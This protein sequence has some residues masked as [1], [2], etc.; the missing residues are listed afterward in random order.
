MSSALAI[1]HTN[2]NLGPNDPAEIIETYRKLQVEFP[3]ATLKA[4]RLD[5]YA[6]DLLAIKDELPVCTQELG[7]TWIHGAGTDPKKVAQYRQLCRLRNDW[8][9]TGSVQA[10]DSRLERFSR[11]LLLVPEHTW[12]MDEKTFLDDYTHY[13]VSELQALRKTDKCRRFE[14]SWAEQRAYIAQAVQALG[15]SDLARQAQAALDRLEPRQSYIGEL[16]QVD[17]LNRVFET[18]YFQIG[19]NEHGAIC[20]LLDRR[21]GRRWATRQHPLGLFQYETFSAQDYER[22]LKQY[23]RLSPATIAWAIKDFTKPGLENTPSAHAVM[24]PE[25]IAL[26]QQSTSERERFVV[27]MHM[28]GKNVQCYGCPAFAM[29]E[30][31]CPVDRAALSFTL[32]WYRK[33]AN[34]MPEAMWFSF[35]PQTSDSQGWTMDKL[36]ARISPLDVVR[37]GNRHL[38]AIQSGVDYRDEHGGFHIASLDAPLV[39]PGQPSLLNFNNRQPALKNGMHF[40][41]YNNIFG[42]NFPM[43]YDENARFRFEF[44]TTDIA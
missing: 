13:S 26:Y 17:D 29:L 27:E 28:P 23:V 38:H 21:N 24:Q 7:D 34:R 39:A 2:D 14:A 16:H 8:L 5:D 33:N 19:F 32:R 25:W 43:W 30:V 42:S 15:E 6:V 1:A 4:G 41:L 12:G 20:Q 44:T 10:E 18:T 37:D 22:Y 11:F 35:Q 31:D 40:N 9:E 36:G 3:T